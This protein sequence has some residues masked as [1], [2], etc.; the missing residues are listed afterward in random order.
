[1]KAIERYKTALNYITDSITMA[2]GEKKKKITTS[3]DGRYRE[4]L[5]EK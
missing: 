1:M 3:K 4:C 5:E 2:V